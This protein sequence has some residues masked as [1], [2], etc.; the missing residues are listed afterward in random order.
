MTKILNHINTY[1]SETDYQNDNSKN[2]PNVSYIEEDEIVMF[3]NKVIYEEEYFAIESLEDDNAVVFKLSSESGTPSAS[4][5]KTIS[6]STDDG[7]TW[8][9][10]TST[11][12]GTTIATLNMG[13]KVLIKGNNSAYYTS[14]GFRGGYNHFTA[15]KEFDVN[16]NIMSLIYGDNFKEQYSFPSGTTYNFGSFFISAPVVSAENL[17]LPATTLANYCYENMFKDCTSLVNAPQL[18]A[19]TLANYCYSNMFNRCTSLVTAPELPAAT[20]AYGCY[21]AMFFKTNIIP[22]FPNIDFTSQINVNGEFTGLF[23][24]TNITD[25]DLERILPKNANGKY[26]LPATTLANNCYTY[27]FQGCTRLVNAP[28]LPATTL[29]TNCY[30]HMFDG[31]TSL[32]TAPELPATTLA[33]G[34]YGYMFKDCTSLAKAPVLPATTL[35]N[36]CYINMFQS[37]TSLVNAPQLPATTLANYCY[38]NMFNRCTSLVTAPELPAATLAYGCYNAM[39]FKTNIIPEFP[40]IDFTSQINV[41][42]EFTGLFAGTNITDADLE[43][44][45]PK[46]ANGKYCLPATTL[47]NNCYTYMFQGCTRLVNAPALPA[48]TLTTNCYQHMFDGCTSLVTAPELPATTLAYGC[49]GYM[50]KDCTSLAKAPVLPAT[51]LAN[52]CYINMFQSCTSLVNAP[53]LPATTLASGCYRD[54]FSGCNSLVTAPQLFATTLTENCYENMFKDCTSLVNAPQLPATTLTS[55]CYQN[56]FYNCRSL[57]T[58]PTLPARYLKNNS[59]SF[60]FQACTNLNYIKAMFT[61][62]PNTSNTNYWV[63]GVAANGTFVKNAAATWNVTGVNGVPSGWTVQK[64]Y[65]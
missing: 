46:N 55:G 12:N 63:S 27:M 11:A 8:T 17:I 6:V 2:F 60:M 32:V 61:T 58:A 36:Y 22:E 59:Y 43:R 62:T 31:C 26:C 30:Q 45:L 16:G 54:M 28:A 47:A 41:N 18:P 19:T 5:A 48:T 15:S 7:E 65:S 23:A 42:G 25:A 56:M 34:C 20:L 64:A 49:Y 14:G 53:Q 29:T 38:S 35:A 24:G 33:Y 21:N 1:Q 9:D 13:E 4:S 39:F 44:I 51:T 10:Y 3:D 40:N 50:F 52:Y 37:C 57:V